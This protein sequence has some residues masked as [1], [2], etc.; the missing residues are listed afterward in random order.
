[1]LPSNKRSLK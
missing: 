1:M